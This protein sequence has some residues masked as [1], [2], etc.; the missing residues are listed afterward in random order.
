[1]YVFLLFLIISS[2]SH[3]S[4]FMKN[5]LQGIKDQQEYGSGCGYNYAHVNSGD[6]SYLKKCK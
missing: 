2:C 5:S 6:N 3:T 1:M 4:D